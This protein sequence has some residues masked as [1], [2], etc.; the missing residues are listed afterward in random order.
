MPAGVRCL[1]PGERG[2]LGVDQLHNAHPHDSHMRTHRK[3]DR[4]SFGP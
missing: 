3:D 1:S 4:I 2:H